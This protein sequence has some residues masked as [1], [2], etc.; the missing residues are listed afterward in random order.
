MEKELV[1][2]VMPAYNAERTI[3]SAIRSVLR[4]S[5]TALELLV[6]DDAS[7]DGTGEIVERWSARDPRVRYL[8]Q[9][10]NSG[11]S[12]SRNIGVEA[13][14]GAWIAFLDS[15]DLWRE[16]KLEKQMALASRHPEAGLFFTGSGFI[17]WDGKKYTH[18]L[19]VPE[20]MDYRK[21]LQQNLISCSSVLARRELMLCY[22]MEN[23]AI[24]EDYAVW[25]RILKEEP[26]AWAVDEPLLIYRISAHSKSGNKGKAARMH[27]E[28]LRTLGEGVP[29][30][31]WNTFL[32]ALRS[33]RKFRAIA[34]SRTDEP[35]EDIKTEESFDP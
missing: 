11:V 25:L 28:T 34:A 13:A 26:L 32:Y 5:W 18:V 8:P 10:R 6:V 33:L 17:T 35:W 4:Q 31:V 20:S 9:K 1:S 12:R 23:D 24:H 27:V 3:E 30:V 29:S 16:D 21:L 14:E 2:V 7:S 19:H 22:P 15:D